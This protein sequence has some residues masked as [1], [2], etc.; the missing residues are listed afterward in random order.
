MQ[1]KSVCAILG[2]TTFTL[3]AATTPT[4]SQGNNSVNKSNQV[5]FFCDKT[6]DAASGEKI[7]ATFAWVPERKGNV[8]VIVW[9]SQFFESSGWTPTK[10]CQTV[11]PKF[12]AFYESGQLNYL[13]TGK[14]NGYVV[15]CSPKA[16]EDCNPNNQLFTIKYGSNPEIVLQQLIG[17]FK[18]SSDQLPFYQSSGGKGYVNVKQ[19]L[20][21]APLVR[22][23]N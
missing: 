10:R 2:L 12:Q 1:Y 21:Q 9:K 4:F 5:T 22:V 23:D 3:A 16:K 11:S 20:K 7:P 19:L 18:Q 17:R 14:I 15:I 13:T 6:F 8:R